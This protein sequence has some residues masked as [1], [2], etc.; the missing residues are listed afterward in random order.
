M[1]GGA[2]ACWQ[3]WKNIWDWTQASHILDKCPTHCTIAPAPDSLVLCAAEFI[4]E[5]QGSWQYHKHPG[6]LHCWVKQT[7][8]GWGVCSWI[9]QSEYTYQPRFCRNNKTF[10]P[11]HTCSKN[12]IWNKKSLGIQ[13]LFQ[14]LTLGMGGRLLDIYFSQ[15]RL[16]KQPTLF[17]VHSK[18]ILWSTQGIPLTPGHSQ[19][20]LQR[21]TL[22]KGRNKA[23]MGVGSLS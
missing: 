22:R 4:R 1:P 20:N 19:P 23:C 8:Y 5:D 6:H 15:R 7:D 3:T 14:S 16:M 2:Q 21:F 10:S 13:P 17:K 9:Q 11:R 12:E 18:Y